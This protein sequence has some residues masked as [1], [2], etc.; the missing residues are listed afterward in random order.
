MGPRASQGAIDCLKY[1]HSHQCAWDELTCAA[2][3]ANG[4]LDCLLYARDHHCPWDERTCNWAVD[5]GHLRVFRYAWGEGCPASDAAKEKVT[6]LRQ[7]QVL[8]RIN[9]SI[10]VRKLEQRRSL[11]MAPMDHAAH[12][13]PMDLRS[14]GMESFD[15]AATGAEPAAEAGGQQEQREPSA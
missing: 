5:N 9:Q 6:R 12:G 13:I 1:A 8:G 3:A 7:G 4:H 2:A 10:M 14:L 11:G 15:E